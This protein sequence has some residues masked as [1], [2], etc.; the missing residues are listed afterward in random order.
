MA[1]LRY[2]IFGMNFGDFHPLHQTPEDLAKKVG[3][4]IMDQP[5]A[6]IGLC[7]AP[8]AGFTNTIAKLKDDMAG[9]YEVGDMFFT[10]TKDLADGATIDEIRTAIGFFN[11]DCPILCLH[12][13]RKLTVCHAG[14]NCL[15]RRDPKEPDIVKNALEGF[16]A[17]KVKVDMFAGIGPCCW[18][19]EY[20]EKPEIKNPRLCRYPTLLQSCIGR[21]ED[22][23]PSGAGHTSVDLYKLTSGLLEMYGVPKKSIYMDRRCTCCDRYEKKPVFWSHARFMADKQEPNI[24]GRNF[25]LAWLE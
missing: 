20:A 18:V 22:V 13:G 6:D 10:R 24:D 9:V 1:T 3:K 17:T 2:S 4:T 12:E 25:S 16:T 8:L 15:I 11:A 14:Y 19:P 23:C 5:A 7:F 21:T